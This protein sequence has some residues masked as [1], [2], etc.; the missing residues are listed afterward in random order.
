L[1]RSACSSF[2][3]LFRYSKYDNELTFALGRSS[4]KPASNGT[5]SG[6]LPEKCFTASI[7]NVQP[8]GDRYVVRHDIHMRLEADVGGHCLADT[9]GPARDTRFAVDIV[10]L[11]YGGF[12][13]I[14]RRCR[15]NIL[16]IEGA[17]EP[18]IAEFGGWGAHLLSPVLHLTERARLTPTLP[19]Y[20]TSAKRDN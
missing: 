13:V 1:P 15:F 9:G 3:S 17:C 5:S 12:G 2:F 11:N 18:D 6:A 7:L 4:D 8:A 14:H 20:G 19:T 10:D 16:S